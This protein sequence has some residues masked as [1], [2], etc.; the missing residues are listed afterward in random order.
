MYCIF[1]KKLNNHLRV[2]EYLQKGR[3]VCAEHLD[4]NYKKP[5][6]VELSDGRE[7]VGDARV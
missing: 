7:S 1:C 2:A 3:S 4:Y 5:K 6:E